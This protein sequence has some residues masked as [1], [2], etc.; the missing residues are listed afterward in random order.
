MSS[1]GPVLDARQIEAATIVFAG[2]SMREAA[3][4]LGVDEGTVRLWAQRP[5]WAEYLR[6]L[7]TRARETAEEGAI[8]VLDVHVVE[9]STVLVELLRSEREETRRLAATAILDRRGIGPHSF[10][11]IGNALDSMSPDEIERELEKELD[12]IRA[13]R[14]SNGDE[15]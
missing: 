7:E 11:H 13:Q 10:N 14:R 4:R 8:R 12:A 9:A 1:H 6:G 5:E 15:A 3:R 2:H